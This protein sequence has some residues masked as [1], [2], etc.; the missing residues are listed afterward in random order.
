MEINPKTNE[1]IAN[2]KLLI[3]GVLPRPIAFITSIGEQGVL[4]AAPYSFFNVVSTDPPMIAVA[5]MRKPGG[6]HKDTARNILESKEFVINVVDEQNVEKV[7][8]TS[9]DYPSEISEV[10]QAGL[11]TSPSQV[12]HVPRIQQAKVHFECRLHQH[13]ELGNG[14]NSDLIIGEIVHIHVDDTLYD[15]GRIDTK[16]LA[17]IGR[18]AGTDYVT[19][20][21]IMSMPRP[22]YKKE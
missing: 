10:E 3:G 5:V 21:N 11:T 2:Y 16:K 20:G 4:N 22:T 19:L 17:P 14:P 12:V 1:R 15:G 9:C 13:L 18:L 8:V 6:V 7:N